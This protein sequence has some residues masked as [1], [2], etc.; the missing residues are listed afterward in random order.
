MLQRRRWPLC[1]GLAVLLLAVVASWGPAGAQVTTTTPASVPPAARADAFTVSDVKVDVSAAN[2]NAA[3]D[4]AIAEAQRKA[5]ETLY[6]RMTASTRAAPR[7]S[8][9]DLA[10]MVQ[11]FEIDDEKVSATRYVGTI[12]VRFR[13]Q[14][15]RDQLGNVGAAY[16][17]PPAQPLVVLPVTVVAGRPVLWEDRTRW[18]EAWE[19]KERGSSLVPLAVPEG[20]MEDFQA[21]GIEDAMKGSAEPL[22]AIARRY[23]AAGVVVAKTELPASG[24]PTRGQPMVVEVTRYGLDGTRDQFNVPVRADASDRPE[25]LLTRAVTFVSAA[26]DEAWRRENTVASGPEQSVAVA[27]PI[28]RLEDWIE[29]RKRLAA[30][31]AV[32]RVD[33]LSLSRVEALVG[34]SYRGDV[35]RLRQALARRDLGLMPTAPRVDAGLASAPTLELRLLPRGSGAAHAATP[36]PVGMGAPQAAPTLPPAEP[37]VVMGAPPRNLGTVPARPAPPVRY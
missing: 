16:V 1:A 35:E 29:T 5:W 34:L 28:S 31:H 8:E 19:A 23:N 33:V 7:V 26:L 9:I 17:E 4:Q 18:R 13:P 22:A 21:I 37:G 14:A 32:S 25:D 36:L 3:R 20:E 30:V 10:R 27:V 15:V 12:T 2:A 6:Q 24:E 11:G